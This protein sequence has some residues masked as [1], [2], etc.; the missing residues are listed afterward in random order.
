M[1][2]TNVLVSTYIFWL[3]LGLVVRD[4][5]PILWYVNWIDR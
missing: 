1:L 2:D 5:G 3:K 4:L